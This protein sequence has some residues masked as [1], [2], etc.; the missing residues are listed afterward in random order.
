MKRLL[1][2]VSIPLTLDAVP[3]LFAVDA[4]VSVRLVT[5]VEH[6]LLLTTGELSGVPE[7]MTVAQLSEYIEGDSRMIA[8]ELRGRLPAN[9]VLAVLDGVV[10]LGS[11][12]FTPVAID[13]LDFRFLSDVYDAEITKKDGSLTINGICNVGSARLVD[14]SGEFALRVAPNP[15]TDN[16]SVEMSLVEDGPVSL[17]LLNNNGQQVLT[18]INQEVQHGLW[19]IEF[20]VN[21]LPSGVYYLHLLT[22]TQS[23][24]APV[25]VVQ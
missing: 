10:L 14:V 6:D 3:P 11:K 12:P 23:I 22:R 17:T 21:Q 20:P 13:S 15:I 5:R 9:G 19:Q 16:A 8:I 2:A 24:T 18:I 7:G 1:W 25:Y 4:D